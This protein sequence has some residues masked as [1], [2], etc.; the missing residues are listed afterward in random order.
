MCPSVRFLWPSFTLKLQTQFMAYLTHQSAIRQFVLQDA[1]ARAFVQ[2]YSRISV[3]LVQSDDSETLSNRVVHVSVQLFSDQDLAY[4]MTDSFHLLHV[5]IVSLKN[6]MKSICVPSTLHGKFLR[7]Q[8]ASV[9]PVWWRE[10]T[11]RD[12]GEDRAEIMGGGA[13]VWCK[14][15]W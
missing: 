5:M 1:F 11:G 8:S 15:S 10:R 2:H 3:M 4:R 6:M 13:E 12:C 7:M 9:R 14:D